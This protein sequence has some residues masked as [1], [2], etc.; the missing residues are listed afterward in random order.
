MCLTHRSLLC[1]HQAD[2]HQIHEDLGLELEKEDDEHGAGV[3]WCPESCIITAGR[4]RF[5]PCWASCLPA[6]V[7]HA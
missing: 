5:L 1:P 7:C 4:T 3:R 6:A 2:I